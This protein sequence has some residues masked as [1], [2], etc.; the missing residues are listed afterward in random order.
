MNLDTLTK[1]LTQRP[2]TR[3]G[4]ERSMKKMLSTGITIEDII[5]NPERIKKYLLYDISIH[6]LSNS[7]SAI[8]A[9][10]NVIENIIEKEEVL[11][12]Y[13]SYF[14]E[15][16]NDLLNIRNTYNRDQKRNKGYDYISFREKVRELI[17]IEKNREY[18]LLMSLFINIPPRRTSDYT[19]LHVNL[20]DDNEHNILIWTKNRKSFI[21]NDWKAVNKIGKQIIEIT[22]KNLIIDIQSY[23]D[24]LSPII[25]FDHI[26]T[27]ISSTCKFISK[28]YKIPFSI[29]DIR[30]LF[31]TFMNDKG[32]PECHKEKFAIQMGTSLNYINTSYDDHKN[33]RVLPSFSVDID[34]I[35]K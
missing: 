21:F 32:L 7:Y 10:I 11:S 20:E 35:I 24:D 15:R 34:D 17:L 8:I 29:Y 2:I 26:P 23:I 30:H 28:K 4:Y 5:Y 3:K 12:I 19:C 33:E 16:S 14:K 6:E 18:R 27:W 1:L 22:N 9:Y 25:I 13:R 31:A